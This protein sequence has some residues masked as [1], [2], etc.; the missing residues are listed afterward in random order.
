MRVVEVLRSRGEEM[1]R[2]AIEKL[3]L[4]VSTEEKEKK[5][6]TKSPCVYEA[7]YVSMLPRLAEKER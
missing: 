5:K 3:V 4:D 7:S 2:S 6:S 1:L